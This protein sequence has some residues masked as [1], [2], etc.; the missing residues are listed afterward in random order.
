MIFRS[1]P[2]TRFKSAD[3]SGGVRSTDAERYI[4]V[5]QAHTVIRI[6]GALM[7]TKRE[8]TMII[9]IATSTGRI[10]LV[11]GIAQRVR[12][13]PWRRLKRA[14]LPTRRRSRR[15]A[16]RPPAVWINRIQRDDHGVILHVY[17]MLFALDANMRRSADGGKLSQSPPDKLTY[18]FILRDGLVFNDG[19]PVTAEDCIASI[20]RWA[21]SDGTGPAHDQGVKEYKTVD[22]RRSRSSLNEPFGLMFQA[23]AKR[24]PICFRSCRNGSPNPIRPSPVSDPIG[25]G[26]FVFVKEEWV[27]GTKVVYR[28]FDK[29]VPRKEPPSAFAGGKIAKVDRVELAHRCD[30]PHGAQRCALGRVDFWEQPSARCRDQRQVHQGDWS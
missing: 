26:P 8:R 28:R 25:S 17:D 11:I 3:N 18:R 9:A 21:V 24:P 5:A 12:R 14:R 2:R 13:R 27:P 6:T 20:K 7:S 1:E 22:R 30:S 16:C 19:A 4:N 29:Y 23:L 10:A 15:A